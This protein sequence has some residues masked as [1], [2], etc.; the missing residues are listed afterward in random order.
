MIVA[1]EVLMR[2]SVV[3][4][5][6][7]QQPLAHTHDM[8]MWFRIS[9]FS[10]V[11]YVHGADQAWHRQH[12]L[13]LSRNFDLYQDL[14]ERRAAFETLF[15]GKAG[16]IAEAARLKADALNAIAGQVLD[17]ASRE[18]DCGHVDK[19]RVAKLISLA[20]AIVPKLEKVRGW[21]G[22]EQRIA[23][24]P[25]QTAW[26]PRFLIDRITRRVLDTHRWRKWH[27]SGVF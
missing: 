26:H 11:A 7:G 21:S 16:E 14:V 15:A 27:R 24:G 25:R 9:A 5:V 19:E 20:R 12:A 17:V 18:I 1:P 2:T 22:F 23:I 10:D 13:S 4:E 6:G 3:N 8:E